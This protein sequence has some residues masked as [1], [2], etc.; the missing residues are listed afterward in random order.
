[1]SAGAPGATAS[2]EAL[3]IGGEVV[4][5]RCV[6]RR[7]HAARSLDRYRVLR[8]IGA[9]EDEITYLAQDQDDPE[10]RV[11]LRMLKADRQVDP[12]HVRRFLA[13]G[14]VGLVVIHPRF[15]ATHAIQAAHGILHVVLDF[16]DGKKLERL[17]RERGPRSPGLALDVTHQLGVVL[18]HARSKRLIVAKRKRSG[19][20]IDRKGQVKVAAFDLVRELEDTAVATLAFADVAS[21]CGLDPD[22]LRAAGPL[23]L[24][25]EEEA[26]LSRLAPETAEVQGAARILFQLVTG[27]PFQVGPALQELRAATNRLGPGKGPLPPPP[28]GSKVR[29]VATLPN[30][31]VRLLDRALVP[32][33]PERITTLEAFERLTRQAQLGL[34]AAEQGT[35]AELEVSDVDDLGDEA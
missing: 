10:T 14:L 11:S 5:P 26:R 2:L 7:L 33:G 3:R 28:Q 18:R 13:R 34:A 24:K 35:P 12:R 19:V 29:D 21:R 25:T 1:V 16:H 22:A 6:D 17:V 30:E 32:M 27:R 8:K 31:V 4:C 15:L 23:T 20:I 9:N